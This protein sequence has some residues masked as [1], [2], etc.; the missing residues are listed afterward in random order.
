MPTFRRRNVACAFPAMTIIR[1]DWPEPKGLAATTVSPAGLIDFSV[2]P[3]IRI[4]H[5]MMS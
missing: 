3:S 5:L 1:A 4:D 2:P